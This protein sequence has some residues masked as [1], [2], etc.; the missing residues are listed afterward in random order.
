MEERK[1]GPWH[2]GTKEQKPVHVGFYQNRFS[3]GTGN[4][5]MGY[6]DGKKWL[7]APGHRERLW[8]NLQWRGLAEKP[9]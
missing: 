7:F 6:W 8:Q 9:E 4:A 2:P 1:L 3:D 5:G